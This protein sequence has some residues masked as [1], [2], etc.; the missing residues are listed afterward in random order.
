MFFDVDDVK[1]RRLNEGITGKKQK[2]GLVVT[3]SRQLQDIFPGIRN[4]DRVEPALNGFPDVVHGD[5]CSDF[6]PSQRR[7]LV[8]RKAQGL[9]MFFNRLLPVAEVCPGVPHLTLDYFIFD[10]MHVLELGI[11]HFLMGYAFT[12]LIKNNFFGHYDKDNPDPVNASMTDNMKKWY[13]RNG[14]M[15]Q[16]SRS[17]LQPRS[18]HEGMARARGG[19]GGVA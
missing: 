7:V 16:I 12:M 8:Y 14:E 17:A 10:S 1:A 4:G 3:E 5:V 15:F 6:L 13:V 11:L 19:G 2:G 9:F 18:A